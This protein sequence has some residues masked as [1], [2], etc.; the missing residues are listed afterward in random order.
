MLRLGLAVTELEEKLCQI[1][2]LADKIVH[3]PVTSLWPQAINKDRVDEWANLIKKCVGEA[4]DELRPTP[5]PSGQASQA[6]S[7]TEDLP[8]ADRILGRVS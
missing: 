4:I 1:Y 6:V 7:G 5:G 2:V 8:A 3:E